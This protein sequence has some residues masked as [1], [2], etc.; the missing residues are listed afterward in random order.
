MIEV[1][2][3]QDGA[4]AFPDRVAGIRE[5]VEETLLLKDRRL[6]RVQVLGLAFRT[7]CPS[8]ESDRAAPLIAQD[9]EETVAETVVRARLPVLSG[10]KEAGLD[11]QALGIG[12]QER[13]REPVPGVRRVAQRQ[14]L[15]QV[16]GDV[17]FL[18]VPRRLVAGLAQLLQ[19][20]A[21]SGG[22]GFVE[23]LAPVVPGAA[24][25]AAGS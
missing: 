25:R 7:Q 23:L 16:G 19:V 24:Q 11:E 10:L 13:P 3:D 20:E 21:V 12:G 6:R 18:Q 5:A 9:E 17:P 14:P 1:A 15:R 8:A 22:D 4:V 2:L